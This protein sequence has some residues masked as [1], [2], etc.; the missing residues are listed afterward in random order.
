MNWPNNWDDIRETYSCALPSEQE[1]RD[2]FENMECYLSFDEHVNMNDE[3][4][5]ST[6]LVLHFT[7]FRGKYLNYIRCFNSSVK[8]NSSQNWRKDHTERLYSKKRNHNSLG[9]VYVYI[10]SH[11]WRGPNPSA[12]SDSYRIQGSLRLGYTKSNYKKNVFPHLQTQ[13]RASCYL[14]PEKEDVYGFHPGKA[15]LDFRL[16]Q[17][18]TATDARK[19]YKV[20]WFAAEEE[21]GPDTLDIR[22]AILQRIYGHSTSGGAYGKTFAFIQTNLTPDEGIRKYTTN[23]YKWFSGEF[24]PFSKGPVNELVKEEHLKGEPAVAAV[25]Q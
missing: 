20:L 10:A 7:P 14:P 5:I 6:N 15:V 1:L 4:K 21:L 8:G 18:L 3:S 13:S 9:T 2:F 22:R 16:I 17:P 19:G 11:L 24:V 12:F 25:S 23:M